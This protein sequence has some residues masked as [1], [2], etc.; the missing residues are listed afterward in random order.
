MKE[1]AMKDIISSLRHWLVRAFLRYP[2]PLLFEGAWTQGELSA[3]R[4]AHQRLVRGS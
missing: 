4:T 3:T 2:F 1:V